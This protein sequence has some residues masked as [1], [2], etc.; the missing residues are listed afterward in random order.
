[1]HLLS[2]HKFH[3]TPEYNSFS[4]NHTQTYSHRSSISIADLIPATW[5]KLSGIVMNIIVSGLLVMLKEVSMR[6]IRR[7]GFIFGP[8]D[9]RIGRLLFL[10]FGYIFYGR[11][12]IL[13]YFRSVEIIYIDLSIELYEKHNRKR[14]LYIKINVRLHPH[15]NFNNNQIILNPNKKKINRLQL[16]HNGEDFPILSSL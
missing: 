3:S 4:L 2:Y 13:F 7:V 11:W 6:A 15:F 12:Y 10:Y 16:Y 9:S 8:V 1:M 14:N 5:A